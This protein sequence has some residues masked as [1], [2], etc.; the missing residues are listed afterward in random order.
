MCGIGQPLGAL[1]RG[2]VGRKG[3]KA[4]RKTERGQRGTGGH[5]VGPR[6]AEGRNTETRA[7]D[8]T[9]SET[10]TTEAGPDTKADR[11]CD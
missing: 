2:T 6:G 5:K 7:R 1:G 8:R 11:R 9:G 3:A 10:E 4:G